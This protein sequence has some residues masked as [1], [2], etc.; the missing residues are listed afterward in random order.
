[1][2]LKEISIN[3]RNWVNS[4][5]GRDYWRALMNAALN[6]LQERDFQE[7]QGV[8]GKTILKCISK[9]ININKKN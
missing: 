6:Y 7:G 2:D 5:Q 1:M 4:A 3:T 8:D 9:E